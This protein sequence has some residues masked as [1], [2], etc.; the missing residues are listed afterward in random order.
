MANQNKPTSTPAK[1]ATTAPKTSA[2][3]KAPVK[4]PTRHEFFAFEKQNYILMI[5]GVII[6][7]LGFTLMSGGGT[8]D[9]NVYNPELFAT[10]RIVIAPMVVVAGYITEI[11]AILYRVKSPNS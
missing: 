11:I 6:I 8:S 4:A 7:V 5:I 3:A 2:A 9:P 1:A 10:R